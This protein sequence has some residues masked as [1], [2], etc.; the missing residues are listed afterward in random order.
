M[1]VV[2]KEEHIQTGVR[3]QQQ[4]LQV[5]GVTSQIADGIGMLFN[6]ALLEEL[7]QLRIVMLRVLARHRVVDVEGLASQ[8]LLDIKCT[9]QAL[10]L[11]QFIDF[12]LGLTAISKVLLLVVAEVHL[13]TSLSQM[14][15]QVKGGSPSFI[16]EDAVQLLEARSVSLVAAEVS[17]HQQVLE[18]TRNVLV[19][20]V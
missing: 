9:G 7:A 19:D 17:R 18:A 16:G 2:I 15:D 10:E 13:A 11:V 1:Q 14:L 12:L 5:R 20:I 3:C 4:V 8:R 6:E